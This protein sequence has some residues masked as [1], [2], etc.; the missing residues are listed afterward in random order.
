MSSKLPSSYTPP[1]PPLNDRTFARR[2]HA[3]PIRGHGRTWNESRPPYNYRGRPTHAAHFLQS[4]SLPFSAPRQSPLSSDHTATSWRSSPTS[5][6]HAT[7]SHSMT[8]YSMSHAGWASPIYTEYNNVASAAP[9]TMNSLVTQSD[10]GALA[11]THSVTGSGSAENAAYK[12]TL[13][14]AVAAGAIAAQAVTESLTS[15]SS[16]N[17]QRCD[18]TF[19]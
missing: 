14:H 8:S 10:S 15:K 12:P 3:G 1:P 9:P 17:V 13:A 18:E 5:T 4:R 6:S 19:T 7:G 2:G 11:L 16:A